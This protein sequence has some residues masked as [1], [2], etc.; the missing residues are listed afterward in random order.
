M[1]TYSKKKSISQTRNKRLTIVLQFKQLMDGQP[2][3]PPQIVFLRR[4]RSIIPINNC[5]SESFAMH[6]RGCQPPNI[7]F[8][9]RFAHKLR[10]Q[11]SRR[12]AS[13][14]L[15]AFA[16]LTVVRGAA[17]RSAS[18]R[19]VRRPSCPLDAIRRRGL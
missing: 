2:W 13:P 3:S 19:R 6:H 12:C 5:R 11:V 17:R 16:R 7:L 1:V 9:V 10:A 15:L 8:G 4:A 14:P 18:S